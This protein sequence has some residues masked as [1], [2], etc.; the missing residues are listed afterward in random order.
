MVA[1]SRRWSALPKMRASFS[2]SAAWFA[3][4]RAAVQCRSIT[5]TGSAA[6][7]GCA[8]KKAIEAPKPTG[9]RLIAIASGTHQ[10]D[11]VAHEF[12]EDAAERRELPQCFQSLIDIRREQ[13]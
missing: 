7:S 6:N 9:L 8:C 2:H 3:V 13:R 1:G 4:G 12:A 11:M 5:G 10:G